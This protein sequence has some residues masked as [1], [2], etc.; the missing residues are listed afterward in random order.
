M[1]FHSLQ[2]QFHR[3]AGKTRDPER[4]HSNQ[5]SG[6]FFYSFG[7]QF[8]IGLMGKFVFASPLVGRK[9]PGKVCIR[10]VQSQSFLVL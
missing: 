5:A 6:N 10:Q 2:S 4:V 7:T 8:R 9:Q 1:E 3:E